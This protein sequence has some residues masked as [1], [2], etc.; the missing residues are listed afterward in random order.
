[1][2]YR[3]KTYLVLLGMA[4]T[5]QTAS[6]QLVTETFGSATD[7]FSI[8]F[9]TIGNPGN[10]ADDTTRTETPGAVAYTYQ[11][12]KY[13]VSR[14]M[15]LKANSAGG[16]EITLWDMSDYGGNGVNRPGDGNELVWGSKVCELAE[17]QQGVPGGLQL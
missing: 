1:M 12:G 17:Y 9:V 4:L 5:C 15:I 11:I 16:L 6:A 3:M 13:E 10:V 14:D 2:I 7:A 8:D